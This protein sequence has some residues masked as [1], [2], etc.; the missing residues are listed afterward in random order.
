LI[1]DNN[2]DGWA[3]TIAWQ[4]PVCDWARL[5][6]EVLYIASDHPARIDQAIAPEQEQV[7]AKLALQIE[8]R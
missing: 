3:A 1:D 2:E 5:A 4:K 7:L 8:L 6:A